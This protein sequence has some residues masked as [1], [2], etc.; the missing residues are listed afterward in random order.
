MSDDAVSVE[1]TDGPPPPPPPRRRRYRRWLG[2]SAALLLV[3]AALAIGALFWALSTGSGSAW[4]VTLVPQLK[5]T[6]PRGSLLGDFAA[7]RVDITLGPGSGTLRLDRPSWQTLQAS[8][9]SAGRWLRLTI[10][11]LHA[12]RITLLPGDVAAPPG[13]PPTAPETLRLPIEIDIRAASVDELRLGAGDD[14]FTLRAL[15][16][17]IHLGDESG[18]LHRFAALQASHDRA[19]ASGD[20]TIKTDPPFAIEARLAAASAASAPAWQASA[21]AT[22]PLAELQVGATARVAAAPPH[23]AQSLDAKAM[24]RPFAAWPL[25]ELQAVTQSLDLSAFAADAPAT[26]LSGRATVTSS[27]RDRPALIALDLRNAR[28][29]RWNE[30][31]LPVESLRA[32]LRARP[33]DPG[34]VE[35]QTFSAELGAGRLAG[36]RIAGAGRWSA[37]RWQ[38]DLTLDKLRPA[39]LDARAPETV[40]DGKLDAVG[41]GFAAATL[42]AARV[43]LRADL[44]GQLA[45]RRLP[46][47]APQSARLRLEALLAASEIVVRHAEASLG[48]ARATLA[49][50]L[51]RAA[52]NAPW[53][54]S[55]RTTL[56]DFDPAPWWP[57]EVDSLLT[58]GTNRLNAKGEFELDLPKATDAPVFKLLAATRG[59]ATLALAE[60]QLAG[61]LLQGEA[62]YANSDGNARARLDLVA[63]GNRLFAEGRFAPNPADDAWQ[64][65]LDAPQL[66]RLAPLVQASDRS[67]ARPATRTTG[68]AAADRSVARAPALAGTLVAR[69]RV[70]GRWP[71]LRS[72]G[73]LQ[74]AT[75]RLGGLAL[76]RGEGRWR[77]GSAADAPT[78]GTLTLDGVDLAGRA[79]E[80]V[81]GELGGTARAHR[82]ELRVESAAL[83]PE[84]VDAIAAMRSGATTVAVAPASSA[85]AAA[86]PTATA[87]APATASRSVLSLSLAGGLVDAGNER[88]AGWSGTLQELLAQS[89]GSPTR[90]WLQ[91]RGLRGSGF[92]AGGPARLSLEPGSV[93]ALGATLRWSRLAWQGAD[94]R[95]S[96]ARLDVS[97]TVEP[98]PVAPLLRAFQ[99]DFGW[100]GDLALGGR[101]EV[102][103][104][105]SVKVDAVVERARGDLSVTDEYGTQ[106]LG[107]SDL[108]LGIAADD[109]IWRYTA[110][111]AGESLGV[112]SGAVTA[113]THGAAAWPD[114]ATPIEGVLELRIASLGTWGRWVPAGW[115]LGGELR[116][117]AAIG[118]R[119]GAPEYTGRVEGSNLGVRNFLQGVNVHDGRVAI[120]LRGSTARIETFTARAGSGSV[121]LEGE[122]SFDETPVARLRLTAERFEMLGRVDRRIVTSGD[123]TLRLDAKTLALEGRFGVDEGLVDFSRSDAPSLGDDVEVIRRPAGAPLPAATTGP[124]AAAAPGAAPPPALPPTARKVDLDLRVGMGEKLHIRGRGLDA[125]LRGDLHITS[126]AGRLDVDGTLR[127]AKG[128]YRAYGQKL[129]IDRG[130]LTFVGPIEN[131]RL[132]IEATRPNLDVRV[133]VIVAGTALN[134]RIRLFSEPAMSDMDKLSWLLLGRANDGTGDTDTALLQRAALALISGEGPGATERIVESFGLDEI[135]VRQQSEGDARETFVRVGKQLSKDWY[136]G[137]ER[138]LNATTGSWQLIYRLARRVTVR[139]QAGGDNSLDLIWTLRWK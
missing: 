94:A 29:G 74:A 18:A 139:A 113:R 131:P 17:R 57:G 95:G 85:P 118:G 20:A 99:P 121:S 6:S 41:T 103:G 135:S 12:D 33:D 98:L 56:A 116:A 86:S 112:A 100:G 9:G 32:E 138:G 31:L 105:P 16:G 129:D 58:R 49:G 30:G 42:E 47:K 76:R 60:S 108:R 117:S 65:R 104:A 84:W 64:L 45:D 78:S 23:G 97:A 126:P 61:V 114:A 101:I 25:G 36:G 7:E 48:G 43:E 11:S 80:R 69:A 136:V 8:R 24:L 87:T 4:V 35:V 130:A 115:R 39:A 40:L 120:A 134:P 110:A 13:A 34:T 119:F 128:T 51:H 79:I 91:A 68:R 66:E 26:S 27:G 37:D 73:E 88:A 54:A 5:V 77:I 21:T 81:R 92:W 71:D 62:S 2:G 75:L 52:A 102:H 46:Q 38:L 137:Y 111:L 122:A 19:T 22:G 89:L 90:I 109:G 96:G 50:R 127:T 55:G 63:T 53:H 15:R 82:L 72:E 132:D 3:L 67:A 133:G 93:E 83:P 59:K 125:G 44:A 124:A 28:T 107:L 106:N 10:A 1:T 123:A 14:A 70:E